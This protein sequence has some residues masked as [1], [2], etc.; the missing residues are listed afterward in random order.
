M[1]R[2]T[3]GALPLAKA[4]HGASG[5]PASNMYDVWNTAVLPRIPQ[6]I[7]ARRFLRPITSWN[8]D[9]PGVFAHHTRHAGHF[10]TRRELHSSSMPLHPASNHPLD[11]PR[12]E[13][14]NTPHAF[15]PCAP[16]I[17]SLSQGSGFQDLGNHSM[18]GVYRCGTGYIEVT[19][20]YYVMGRCVKDIK[21]RL[22]PARLDV[23]LSCS[24]VDTLL[25]LQEVVKQ[26]SVS[27]QRSATITNPF[28]AQHFPQPAVR[29]H[30]N[31]S[32]LV[33]RS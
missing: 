28:E 9:D 11:M 18:V 7:C 10:L 6:S 20:V 24:P 21:Y 31:T 8:D 25:T 5:P 27:A 16:Y 23:A 13:L 3:L 19:R 33:S 32:W 22:R 12:L 30:T 2:R 1:L 26:V 17:V 15:V 14:P 29:S 4:G